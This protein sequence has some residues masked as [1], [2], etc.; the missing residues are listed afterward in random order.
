MVAIQTFAYGFYK[1]ASKEAYQE[2]G[3]NK[4]HLAVYATFNSVTNDGGF[5]RTRYLEVSSH[6]REWLLQVQNP[7]VKPGSK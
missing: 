3:A 1:I 6:E 4:H 2:A 7:P 5:F